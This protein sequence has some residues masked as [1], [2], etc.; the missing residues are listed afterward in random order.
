MRCSHAKLFY[1]R[2]NVFVPHLRVAL[3]GFLKKRACMPTPPSPST[4]RFLSHTPCWF[5]GL[6]SGSPWFPGPSAV[7]FLGMALGRFLGVLQ[8][9]CFALRTYIACFSLLL[10]CKEKYQDASNDSLLL[11]AGRV[12]L[13]CSSH[14]QNELRCAQSALCSVL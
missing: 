4:R 7:G 3:K 9:M 11:A 5:L 13:A 14:A 12:H 6:G 8:C 10:A 2:A 1:L